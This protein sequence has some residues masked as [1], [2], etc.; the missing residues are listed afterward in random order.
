VSPKK[1]KAKKRKTKE[2]PITSTSGSVLAP[3]FQLSKPL[4]PTAQIGVDKL[5]RVCVAPLY[6]FDYDSTF[7]LNPRNARQALSYQLA[8]LIF[9][10]IRVLPFWAMKQLQNRMDDPASPFLMTSPSSCRRNAINSERIAV[11]VQVATK[12]INHVPGDGFLGAK[13]DGGCS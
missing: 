12:S 2:N 9:S 10:W 7:N 4:G 8:M 6:Q 13:K 11:Q 5:K 3:I 1:P